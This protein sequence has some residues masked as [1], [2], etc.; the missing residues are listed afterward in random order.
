MG[1]AL[2]NLILAIGLHLV[3]SEGAE[4]FCFG[5]SHES[6]P[7]ALGFPEMDTPIAGWFIIENPIKMDDL[8]VPPFLEMPFIILYLGQF[9]RPFADVSYPGLTT[10]ISFG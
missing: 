4:S 7:C 9:V 10:Q 6:S 5:K 8:G 1:Y 2:R 3:R